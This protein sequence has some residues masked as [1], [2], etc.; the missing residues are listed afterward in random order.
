MT[1]PP[2][3]NSQR[4]EK[5]REYAPG[6]SVRD[7]AALVDL[8][9]APERH[10][11]NLQH[12]SDCLAELDV[13]KEFARDPI[14]IELAL[15]FHDAIYDPKKNDNEE[16]S[17][18]FAKIVLSRAQLPSGRIDTVT[19]LIL[20]TK[21]HASSD[22][23]TR[24]LIDIDLAILGQPTERF[25][26]YE[27]QIR[28]EYGWVTEPVFRGKRLEILKNFFARTSIYATLPFALKYE[29]QARKNLQRSILLLGRSK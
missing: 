23:D 14:S 2:H 18:E 21:T 15:W 5:L 3:I 4:W 13:V 8:Y 25:D 24:L 17:A 1:L 29:A 16:Q 6:L 10:Y 28:S 22:E 20:A 9:R 12:V 11:H 27:R 26:Q 7:H 19:R